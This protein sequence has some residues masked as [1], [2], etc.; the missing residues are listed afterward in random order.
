REHVNVELVAPTVGGIDVGNG[1]RL[2]ADQKI[3]GG[4]SVLY[5]AV[6]VLTS[7]DGATELA[8]MPAARDFVTDAYAH[9]KFI[10]FT[11]DAGPLFE[12]SGV[13]PLMDGGFIALDERSPEDFIARCGELRF[14]DRVPAQ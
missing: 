13:A 10:G 7:K 12:A 3:D 14:W 11:G 6:V 8:A 9:C 4:P 5:D 2:P 1:A